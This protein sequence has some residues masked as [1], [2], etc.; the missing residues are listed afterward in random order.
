M[1]FYCQDI[2]KCG[3]KTDCCSSCHEDADEGYSE[4][5]EVYSEDAGLA[6]GPNTGMLS[7]YDGEGKHIVYMCCKDSSFDPKN[8]KHWN[9]LISNRKDVQ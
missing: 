3:F 4:L 6:K 7:D 8:P 5:N 1:H 9:K 2:I